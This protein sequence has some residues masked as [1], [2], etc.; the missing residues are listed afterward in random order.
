MPK[1][2]RTTAVIDYNHE[3]SQAELLEIGER[4][5]ELDE[6]EEQLDREKNLVVSGFKARLS[7]NQS[8]RKKLSKCLRTGVIEKTAECEIVYDYESGVVQYRDLESGDV[9]SIRDMTNEERQLNLF[10]ET[11][12][13]KE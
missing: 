5:G 1:E 9:V 2:N 10:G 8:E 11:N 12:P 7:E 4:I 6:Q 13:N 3:L